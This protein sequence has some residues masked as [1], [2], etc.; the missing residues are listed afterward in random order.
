MPKNNAD[1]IGTH[2]CLSGKWPHDESLVL[3]KSLFCRTI[4]ILAVQNKACIILS[5]S[6]SKDFSRTVCTSCHC[7]STW[8]RFS[9]SNMAQATALSNTAEVS[10]WKSDCLQ[11]E[12]VGKIAFLK[13][14][15]LESD[16]NRSKRS[17]KPFVIGRKNWLFANDTVPLSSRSHDRGHDSKEQC[18]FVPDDW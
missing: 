12:S 16:N 17:I 14:G 5:Y 1:K 7:R 6:R 10:V 11:P 2:G 18:L 9:F 15:R 4:E 8:Q 13:D 3:R